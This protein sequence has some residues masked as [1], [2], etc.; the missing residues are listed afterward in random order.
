M[1]DKVYKIFTEAEWSK[2]QETG[3]FS[4]SADDL[5]DGFIHLS[6]KEQVAGV[7]ERFFAGRRPLYVAEFA[8]PGFLQRVIW[9][10]SSSGDIYP[11]L[12]G[13]DLSL[14]EILDFKKL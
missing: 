1:G 11:H 8:D 6:T 4:G 7:I 13:S 12:Y 2:F 5:R 10:S 9:E 14:G 3:R